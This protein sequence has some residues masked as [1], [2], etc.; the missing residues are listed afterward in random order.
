MFN[1]VSTY[2]IQFHKD[3][4]FRHFEKIIPYLAKLGISTIYASPIFKAVPG[5]NHGYDG[6]DPLQINPEIGTLEQLK[7]ISTKLKA[8]GIGWIQDIVPNHLAY[9]PDNTWL[10]DLLQNGPESAYK[11]YFEQSLDDA[12]LF[13]GPI[14]V[15]F[16]G[17]DLDAVIDNG[18]LGI[19]RVKGKLFFNYADS[20]WPL[21]PA[22]YPPKNKTLAVINGDKESLKTIT[23]QQHYRFCS[24]KETDK[25]I[26]F[27][28]FFT[29]NGLICLNIQHDEV[30]NHFHQLIHA[31]LQQDVIQGLRIDHVDGLYDPEKYLQ[32]LRDLTGPDAY[33]I[34]EKILEHEEEMP[35]WPV[36]GN[37]G[38][39]FLAMVNN[40]LT[41]RKSEPVFTS[42]YQKLARSTTPVQEQI[43]RKKAYILHQQ[44]AGELENLSRLFLTSGFA[45]DSGVSDDEV[46][47]A[48]AQ[49]LICCPVYRYYEDH[50]P[51]KKIF[52]EL[53]NINPELKHA[54]NLLKKAWQDKE[55]PDTIR[56]FRRCMQFTGPLMAKGVE[57]TL[58]YTYNRFIAH[59][60]VGDT[61]DT[62]GLSTKVFHKAM[63]KR[64]KEWPLSINGT[65]THDTKRGEDAR[66]RLNVIT[67]IPDEWIEKVTE[68]Q[69]LNRHLKQNNIPDAN[70][71]YFIYETLLGTYP[72]PGQDE[73]NYPERIEQYLEKTLREA[74]L[75]SGWAEPNEEYEAGT[76]QFVKELLKKRGDFWQSFKAFHQ[77]AAAFG[78]VNS[79]AQLLLKLTAPGTP[80]IYQ[81]CELWDLSMVDPDNRRPVDYVLRNGL[82][83]AGTDIGQL[84]DNKFNGHIKQCL[85]S[86]VL[87]QRKV[88]S[89]LFAE[90]DYITLQTEGKF[91][92]NLL[93]F[94]RKYKNTCYVIAIPL[95]LAG[96]TNDPLAVEWDDTAI[97]LPE[98][99]PAAYEHVL[100]KTK[101]N[102]TGKIL[103]SSIFKQL[104]LAFLKFESESNQRGSGILAH[105]TSLPSAFGAGDMGPEAKAFADLLHRAGQK[106]WQLLPLSPVNDKAQ[107]SPYSSWSAMG[108][109]VSLI[110]L[111]LL[112]LDGLLTQADLDPYLEE[113]TDKADLAATARVK[114]LLLDKAWENYTNEK[115]IWLAEPFAAFCKTEDYWLNDFAVYS[116]LKV[117][118]KNLPWYQWP[119]KY[120]MRQGKALLNL[121]TNNAAKIEQVKWH[122]FIF[123][124]QWKALKR[125]CNELDI[126]IIGDLPFYVGYDSVDVWANPQIFALDKAGEMQFVAGVP[127]DYFNADGQ[128]WGMPVFN[129]EKLKQQ[130]YDWWVKRIQKNIGMFDML[131]LDHFRA[132]SSYWSVAATE[133]TAINGEWKK[134]PGDDFFKVLKKSLGRLPFI[135]ED[136]G[137]ID[138]AVYQLRDAWGLPG[139][140][141]LQFAFGSTAIST[142][143]PHNYTK[144]HVVYTGT[145][146][147]NTARGWFEQ[148][149][150]KKA[151]NELERY[152]GAKAKAKNINRL[153][154]K[155]AIAS[156]ANIAIIPVQDLLGFDN[157]ARMNQP[158]TTEGNWAW[159]LTQADLQALPVKKLKK[160]TAFYNRI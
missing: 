101:D 29:V 86:A 74:K 9:H 39:D 143:T 70:D 108:G 34:V 48:I 78:V 157:A 24:W 51:L 138:E 104:P 139:M 141:V 14:M 122:Q 95:G 4:T 89:L 28:R 120:K 144:N 134:G 92:A 23:G 99:M 53:I 158:A 3:F 69:N 44:M 152:T 37:T 27:R 84:W 147:N 88:N 93:A 6:T 63:K 16:L 59:N 12:M 126:K 40:L 50:P 142:H 121:A 129:W 79:L 25:Q 62:F 132:F 68:W 149:A 113:G 150:G 43:R 52:K 154:I 130:H 33:I 61:P 128:L 2:R 72:M 127:P 1:P 30:F 31:L 94:A 18:E 81:G 111:E 160:L 159:R 103:V 58:M 136:L 156:V 148:E 102:A 151:R 22:S 118:Y 13:K 64:L 21:Q 77:K 47:R 106:Y 36:Q 91:K 153:F 109:N 105:I 117:Q 107:F 140:K 55:N 67:D 54:V 5:S 124:R 76:M 41:N 123:A 119:V 57:D 75:H 20:H 8:K 137:D 49:L 10:M 42:F 125:H 114:E 71:E 26:N 82:L 19:V 60:E 38:Y 90:G 112:V 115:G 11:H 96:I 97:I 116:V 17:D 100:F 80:D 15:P 131:R 145:H 133:V 87:R 66:A 83:E 155:T 56:F 7:K 110:S 32:Q 135:A 73:D 35:A 45:K 65:S 85:L 98:S 146:D 46:K